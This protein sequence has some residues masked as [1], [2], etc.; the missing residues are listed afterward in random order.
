MPGRGE[1]GKTCTFVI[2][3]AAT[4]AIVLSNARSSSVGKPTITSVVR[5]K[6]SSG[7]IRERYCPIV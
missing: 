3:T 7:S 1:Y 4:A 5:L 2:P 6:S